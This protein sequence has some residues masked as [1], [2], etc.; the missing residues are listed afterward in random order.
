MRE[1]ICPTSKTLQ[2]T[3]FKKMLQLEMTL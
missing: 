3:I 1:N 2:D